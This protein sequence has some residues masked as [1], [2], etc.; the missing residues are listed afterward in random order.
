VHGKATAKDSASLQT[1]ERLS[2]AI[3]RKRR[4]HGK[5]A[6]EAVAL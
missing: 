1:P 5:V 3:G 6:S 2:V 4:R